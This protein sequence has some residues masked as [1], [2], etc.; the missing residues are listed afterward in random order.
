MEIPIVRKKF[1]YITGKELRD[2]VEEEY[3]LK[4]PDAQQLIKYYPDDEDIMVI[5]FDT[6]NN[7]NWKILESARKE[8]LIIMLRRFIK[9]NFDD[10]IKE[11]TIV[12]QGN[13]TLP[14]YLESDN[15]FGIPEC[16]DPIDI[17]LP[18]SLGDYTTMEFAISL[19]EIID[20]D[21]KIARFT[22][23]DILDGYS[24]VV[25]GRPMDF[26]TYENLDDCIIEYNYFHNDTNNDVYKLYKV[27]KIINNKVYFYDQKG[28]LLNE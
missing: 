1:N 22:D 23:D 16:D 27:A 19:V 13:W 7:K 28:V 14:L 21:N 10:N 11:A 24:S 2:L 4:N 26:P 15:Y 17:M 6:K 5:D 25:I 8:L 9:E 3:I 18:M 20:K 12:F